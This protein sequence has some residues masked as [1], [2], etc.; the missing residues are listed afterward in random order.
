MKNHGFIKLQRDLLSQP[1]V[2]DMLSIEGAAGLGLYVALN[3]YLAH[4]ADGWGA[5]TGRQLS[6]LAVQIRKHRS[7]VNRIITDYGLF[8]VEGNRFTSLWMQRQYGMDAP[9]MRHSRAYL[10]MRAEEIEIDKEKENKEKA[11]GRVS[12]DTPPA[13]ETI[14]PSAYETVD[15]EGLR[16]GSCGET[17][18]WWAPPQQDLR[19][20]WSAVEDRW[21]PPDDYDAEA[22]R[23]RRAAMRAED[24]MMKTAWEQLND[25]DNKRIEDHARRT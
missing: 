1:K 22:E 16:H 4:C 24:F 2:A 9:T 13:R 6:S 7:D 8:V 14:G 23:Q 15:R 5:Y 10:S 3:L 25:N 21:V 17:V 19:T 11:A 20:R 18:G 12:A